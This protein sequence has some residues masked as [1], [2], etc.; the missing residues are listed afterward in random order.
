[1]KLT[2]F[3]LLKYLRFDKTQPFISITALL[4]FLG[5]GVGVMVLIVA[6]A[7]M[8]GMSKEFE[9]K[10][11]VMNYPLSIFATSSKGVPQSVLETLE[12]EFPHLLF[13][14][15]LQMQAVAR[16]GSEMSAGMIF[17]VDMAREARINEVFA[18]AYDEMRASKMGAVSEERIVEAG[19]VVKGGVAKGAGVMGETGAM[20]EAGVMSKASAMGRES[21]F[22]SKADSSGAKDFGESTR[23]RLIVGSALQER[24]M[25]ER[26][27]KLTL[28]F[29]KLEPT[30]L[31]L[32][33]LMKRFDIA[34]VFD[35]GIKAYDLGYFYT[36]FK[37]LARLRNIKNG[38]FDGI[39]V[40][41]PKPME[42]IHALREVLKRIPHY[43][44]GLE[45]WWQQNGNF[46]AA[47]AL[48][49]RALFIVLMLIILMAS[50]NIISSLL[51]VIMNRR[52]EIALLLSM[53]ASAREIK[54][55]FFW[56]GNAIG[57]GGIA[58]GV[59]LAFVAMWIL[60]TFPI[61][62]LPAD[63]YGVSKLPLDLALWDLVGTIVGAVV[64]VCASSYYPAHRASKIDALYVLRN[65]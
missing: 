5:V 27:D 42:D 45:G 33:P 10:L 7:I 17:G 52:K 3:L 34:G 53:G 25:L 36:D 28:F 4:A 31:V 48:E 56:L 58:L 38:V 15:Y 13:S 51:M 9:K 22:M 49:K 62:S 14:P 2:K 47:M 30:G 19:A 26:G 65:E 57:F 29:T 16:S 32:S 64:I 46:F 21:S 61:I 12:R 43:G 1:M 24:F 11:F 20:G 39:H 37:S 63:V 41:S 23:F 35:S 59:V 8:N 54:Q 55:V 44:V 50:L 40:Y 60:G 18:K 6:M